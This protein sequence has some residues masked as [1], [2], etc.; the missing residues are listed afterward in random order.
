MFTEFLSENLLWAGAFVVVANLL[1]LSLLQSNVRGAKTVSALELPQLQRG[2]KWSIIDVN[3]AAQFAQSHIPD[4]LNF[5]LDS[6][7]ADNKDLLK[8][9]KHTAIVVCQTG[10]KSAKAV[11]S[12]LA[13]GIEDIHVLRGGLQSW[14]KENLPL[15]AS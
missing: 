6:I 13:L 11:K 1:I 14:S 4:S 7:N 3:D 2:G 5:P 8:L 15:S 10:S 9:K 12:L